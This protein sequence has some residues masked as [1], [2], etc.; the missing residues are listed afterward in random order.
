MD[1]IRVHSSGIKY[2]PAMAR[3]IAEGILNVVISVDAGTP[4]TYLKIKNVPT[5]DKV[6]ENIRKYAEAQTNNKGLARTKFIIIPGVN[7]TVEELEKWFQL[8]VDAGVRWIVLDLEGGWYQWHKHEVPDHVYDLLD[9]GINRAKELGMIRCELY[10]RA[11]DMN[12]H[13]GEFGH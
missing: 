12:I 10:D 11:N 7:D 2:S 5:F 13:R 1:N 4:E 3:G 9:Y 6:W 8:T